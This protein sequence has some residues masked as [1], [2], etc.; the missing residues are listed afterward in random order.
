MNKLSKSWIIV[1]LIL[2]SYA[3]A[4]TINTFNCMS[5][6]DKLIDENKRYRAYYV[7]AEL[8][9]DQIEEENE[10]AFD[11]DAGADYLDARKDVIKADSASVNSNVYN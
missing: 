5:A 2:L 9:F 6:N 8:L 3:V 10:S 4:I 7:N 11:T 1:L